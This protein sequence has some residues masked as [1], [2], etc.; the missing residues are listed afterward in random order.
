[1]TERWQAA[2]L[3]HDDLEGALEDLYV[4]GGPRRPPAWLLVPRRV[5][6]NR[7]VSGQPPPARL[8]RINR[9]ACNG[10]GVHGVYLDLADLELVA[11]FE[12]HV[13][14]YPMESGGAFGAFCSAQLPALL[15]GRPLDAFWDPPGAEAACRR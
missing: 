3:V 9:Y 14:L 10:S 11:E 8:M 7:R 15:G 5:G 13:M 12:V 1:M 4:L 2:H 6:D